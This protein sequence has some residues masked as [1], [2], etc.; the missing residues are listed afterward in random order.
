[1]GHPPPPQLGSIAHNGS[2]RVLWL[3]G[4]HLH[5]DERLNGRS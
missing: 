5:L 3:A 1:M 4:R 2:K